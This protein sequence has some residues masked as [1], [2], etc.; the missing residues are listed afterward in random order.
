MEKALAQTAVLI[1]LELIPNNFFKS[2]CLCTWSTNTGFF[3][4]YLLKL[5][6]LK[7]LKKEWRTE[8]GTA[9]I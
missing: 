8:H 6:L 4:K 7:L 3:S 1:L 5:Y 9:F 2:Q